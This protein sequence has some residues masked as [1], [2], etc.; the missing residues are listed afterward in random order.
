MALETR[1]LRAFV[2]VAEELSFVRAA[3]RLHVAQPALSRTI[4]GIEDMLG[5]QLFERTTRN[6]QMTE[7]GS[8]FLAQARRT[9]DQMTRT[10]QLTRE[11]GLGHSGNVDV[12]YMDFAPFGP[13]VD[14]LADYRRIYP[15]V[16]VSLHRRRSDEQG[17]DVASS[18]LDLGF[19]MQHRFRPD[20]DFVPLTRE[21]LVVL[22]PA[23]HRLAN[24][25]RV[26]VADLADEP[27]ITG[28][29]AGWFFF[30]PFVEAFCGAAGFM[31]RIAYE[32]L[33]G[34]TIFTLVAAGLGVTIYPVCAEKA[35]HPG[36]VI[37]HFIEEPPVI[38]TFGVLRRGP[39]RPF[40]AALADLVRGRALSG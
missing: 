13:M 11:A 8:V 21:P 3:E 31:P 17:E 19:T 38:E 16:K 34:V 12:G 15:G 5:V 28:Q 1:Q 20:V 35:R 37:R 7:A 39:Y 26:S 6:V 14:I 18:H 27:F 22:L 33:E 2:A 24:A 36:I 32:A 29:R 10:V 40:V 23:G 9:V 30:L 4:R 25:E